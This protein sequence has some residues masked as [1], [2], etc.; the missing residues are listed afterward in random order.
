VYRL[1]V[2]LFFVAA[3][4][5]FAFSS[6]AR[7]LGADRQVAYTQPQLAMG[8]AVYTQYCSGCH[9]ATLAG[10]PASTPPRPPL[11]GARFA[12][13]WQGKTASDLFAYLSTKMPFGKGGTLSHDQYLAATAYILSQ[14]S[15][16]S[17]GPLLDDKRLPTIQLP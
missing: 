5:A 15:V 12:A 3:L 9:L 6:P 17:V 2:G 13:K 1:S 8:Q 16:D 7:S 4:A 10:N 11:A 14:N